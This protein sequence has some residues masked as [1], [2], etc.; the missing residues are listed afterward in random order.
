MTFGVC[1][2]G[3]MSG[4]L[5]AASL[6]GFKSPNAHNKGPLA[7]QGVSLCQPRI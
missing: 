4:L 2:I 1:E 7:A 5:A 3:V 6:L